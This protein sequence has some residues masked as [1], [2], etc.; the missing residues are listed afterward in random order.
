ME[1]QLRRWA[2]THR[3]LCPLTPSCRGGASEVTRCQSVVMVADRKS[4]RSFSWSLGGGSL[5]QRTWPCLQVPP[6]SCRIEVAEVKGHGGQRSHRPGRSALCFYNPCA[7]FES[8]LLHS[9]LKSIKLLLLWNI[10]KTGSSY[11]IS[12]LYLAKRSDLQG[13]PVL[14]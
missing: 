8:I 11:L 4:R 5:C 14:I 1:L 13:A 2:Q 3:N 10:S 7:N 12:W 6:Q 9:Q